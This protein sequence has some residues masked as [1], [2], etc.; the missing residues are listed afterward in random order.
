M[1]LT[2]EQR[3]HILFV[4]ASVKQIILQGGDEGDMLGLVPEVMTEDFRKALGS[5]VDELSVY[6]KKY[7]GF[8]MMMKFIE[9][10]ADIVA[11]EKMKEGGFDLN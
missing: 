2:L 8:R 11:T 3:Q 7:E 1:A 6:A 10:I 9:Q 5:S 4:D